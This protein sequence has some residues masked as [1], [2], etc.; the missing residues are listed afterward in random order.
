M[1]PLELGE[2][3]GV[4]VNTL[5]ADEKYPVQDCQSLPLPNQMQLSEKAKF[6]SQ[7]FAPF[8]ESNSNFKLFERKDDRHSQSFSEITGCEKLG[9]NTL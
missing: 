6:S 2:I 7:S 5:T 3:L 8:L 1:S 4:F 9:S